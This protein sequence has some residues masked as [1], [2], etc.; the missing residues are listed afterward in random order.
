MP[1]AGSFGGAINNVGGVVDIADSLVERNTADTGAGIVNYLGIARLSGS[2]VR[3]NAALSGDGGGVHSTLGT[4]ILTATRVSDNRAR[5]SAGILSNGAFTATAVTIEDNI[6]TVNVGG[7][8]AVGSVMITG[9]LS[10][11]N[12]ASLALTPIKRIGCT[13]PLS[14]SSHMN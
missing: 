10:A 12:H 13:P 9:K 2:T 3:A 4:L 11:T 6:A 7:I 14:C 1:D 8:Q 5:N